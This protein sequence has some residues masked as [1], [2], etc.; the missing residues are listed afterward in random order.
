MECA[1]LFPM[2]ARLIFPKRE[3]SVCNVSTSA[4]LTEVQGHWVSGGEKNRGK[5][6]GR[7]RDGE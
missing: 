1:G 4:G 5:G 2:E 3:E 6:M 7:E